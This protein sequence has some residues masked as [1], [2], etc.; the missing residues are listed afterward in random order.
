MPQRFRPLILFHIP[1]PS[2][3]FSPL[4][5]MV[6][7]L[8]SSYLHQWG[9]N[10]HFIVCSIV[11]FSTSTFSFFPVSCLLSWWDSGLCSNNSRSSNRFTLLITGAC[12]LGATLYRGSKASPSTHLSGSTSS[13]GCVFRTIRSTWARYIA[14]W[15]LMRELHLG[16]GRSNG[17][18]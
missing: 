11:P 12:V 2:K 1:L 15:S 8:V 4:A 5:L 13:S 3:R 14:N 7:R 9:T 17:T 6:F 18:R 16:E 10:P